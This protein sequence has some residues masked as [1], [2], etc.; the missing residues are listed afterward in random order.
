[1]DKD[2]EKC[3]CQILDRKPFAVRSNLRKNGKKDLEHSKDVVEWHHLL[4][5][6]KVLNKMPFMRLAS[7]SHLFYLKI[8]VYTGDFSQGTILPTFDKEK[9]NGVIPLMAS[10]SLLRLTRPIV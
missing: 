3:I 2:A 8:G 7:I 9:K 6:Q 1:M 5:E 10:C 4:L